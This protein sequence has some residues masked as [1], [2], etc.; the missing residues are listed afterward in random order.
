MSLPAPR[1][2]LSAELWLVIL[3]PLITI[4]AGGAMIH[5]ASSFGFTAVGENVIVE[6]DAH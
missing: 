5:V 3:I 2:R 6:A 1:P 4:L